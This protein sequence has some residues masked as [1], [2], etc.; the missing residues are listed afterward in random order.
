MVSTVKALQP[1]WEKPWDSFIPTAQQ[2]SKRP[3]RKRQHQDIRTPMAIGAVPG[4]KEA[5]GS[6]RR[7]NAL[8]EKGSGEANC[9]QFYFIKKCGRKDFEASLPKSFSPA[10]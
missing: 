2:V 8:P 3:A 9:G 1:T 7:R 4:E 6:S 5:V 10:Y